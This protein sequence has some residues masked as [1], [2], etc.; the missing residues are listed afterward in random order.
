MGARVEEMTK[1]ALE[2]FERH[3]LELARIAIPARGKFHRLRARLDGRQV[4]D[5]PLGLRDDLL[6]DDKNV[7]LA[8]RQWRRAKWKKA[9][10]VLKEGDV[11]PIFE[12]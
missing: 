4:H 8:Q 1:S 2:A 3:D 10:V 11:I 9:I 7:V 12:G 5:C 6:R